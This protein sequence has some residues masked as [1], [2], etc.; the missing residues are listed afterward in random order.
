MGYRHQWK[1]DHIPPAISNMSVAPKT[2]TARTKQHLGGPTSDLF[3]AVISGYYM[4]K[5]RYPIL[6]LSYSFKGT[7]HTVICCSLSI[8]LLLGHHSLTRT[9]CGWVVCHAQTCKL[10]SGFL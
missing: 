10:S 9:Q 1:K 2:Q 6:M 4:W 3:S 7:P 8:D 5:D